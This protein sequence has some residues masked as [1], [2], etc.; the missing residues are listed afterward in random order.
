M[1]MDANSQKAMHFISLITQCQELALTTCDAGE[2]LRRR[3]T[4]TWEHVE[5]DLS[6]W[7][8]RKGDFLYQLAN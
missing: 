1:Q 4:V 6:Q 5:G 7:S 2:F 3:A 8:E